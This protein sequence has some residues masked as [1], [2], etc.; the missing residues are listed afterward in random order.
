MTNYFLFDSSVQ[1]KNPIKDPKN[2]T[3]LRNV[4]GTSDHVVNPS[5]VELR[6]VSPFKVLV[7]VFILHVSVYSLIKQNG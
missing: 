5:G 1:N 7:Y 2:H 4:M 6:C 3:F